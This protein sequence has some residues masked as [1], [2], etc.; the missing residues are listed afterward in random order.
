MRERRGEKVQESIDKLA[1]GRQGPGHTTV[2]DKGMM[3]LWEWRHRDY[4]YQYQDPY[5][6]PILPVGHRDQI[7][8]WRGGRENTG[9]TYTSLNTAHA[10]PLPR[11]RR[12]R[13]EVCLLKTH[14]K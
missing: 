8:G 13:N 6:S 7:R 3:D 12:G 14:G 10:T 11:Y 9:A 2:C 5:H 1:W 4:H